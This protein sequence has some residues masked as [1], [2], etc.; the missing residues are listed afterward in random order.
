MPER[1]REEN[2]QPDIPAGCRA[3][4]P[5]RIPPRT[6]YPCKLTVAYKMTSVI[7]RLRLRRR[8]LARIL[9]GSRGSRQPTYFLSRT[10][11]EIPALRGEPILRS[12]YIEETPPGK[13]SRR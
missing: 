2:Y 5:L 7:R 11:A 12:V 4:S 3:F 10:K 8:V 1:G 6:G 13:P 9:A